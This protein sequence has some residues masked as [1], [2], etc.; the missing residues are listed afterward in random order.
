[1]PEMSD[2]PQA[3]RLLQVGEVARV[4]SAGARSDEQIAAALPWIT[5]ARQGRYYRHAAVVLGLITNA[6][7]NSTLTAVGDEFA[8]IRTFR[9]RT[10]FLARRLVDTE[11]FRDGL[12]YI[13]Q[14]SPTQIEF[15]QWFLS[16]YPGALNTAARRWVTFANFLRDSGIVDFTGPTIRLVC[17]AGAVR[18]QPHAVN[19]HQ[20]LTGRRRRGGQVLPASSASGMITFD[21]DSQLRER[22]SQIHWRLVD[23]KASFL[24]A[25]R[26]T[27]MDT[28]QID[29]FTVSRG[30][31]ILYEMKSTGSGAINLI[32][33]IRKAVAQLFEYR[34]LYADPAARLCIVT[35]HQVLGSD[36][37]L[38]HYLAAAQGIA[39]EW[40][41]DFQRFHADAISAE[42]LGRFAP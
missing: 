41:T 22:A 16:Y 11:I 20:T 4:V 8:R 40:T 35:N 29:L 24:S 37:W 28:R 3:D 6:R 32:S 23:G 31:S 36:A 30:D 26:F 42:L 15:R 34:Y 17:F 21:V 1:M 13:R 5:A 38:L 9:D 25:R 39:Y 18:K 33:Q 2:F 12:D 27:P 19:P 14:N 7:N 10:D